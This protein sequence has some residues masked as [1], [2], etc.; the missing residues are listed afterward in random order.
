MENQ[1][2]LSDME[3]KNCEI[4]DSWEVLKQQ[5]ADESVELQKNT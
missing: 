2:N 1:E 4:L 3:G 5:E